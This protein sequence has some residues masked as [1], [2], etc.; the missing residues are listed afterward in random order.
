MDKAKLIMK[1]P[2][3]EVRIKPGSW[4]EL[5]KMAET[6]HKA[7]YEP[8]EGRVELIVTGTVVKQGEKLAIELDR[9]AT[10]ATVIVVPARNDPDTAE[11]LNRHVGDHVEVEGLW[12][13]AMDGGKGG[14]AVTAIYGAED[15]KPKR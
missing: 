10:P 11:H 7:G 14:L 15:K 3:M 4:P 2:H 5:D 8:I 1:P 6:I 13:P 9:M 12:Q